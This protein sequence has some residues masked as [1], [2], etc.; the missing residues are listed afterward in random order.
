MKVRTK[1]IDLTSDE[2]LTFEERDSVA[3]WMGRD[4]PFL[5]KE[6]GYKQTH[7]YNIRNGENIGYAAKVKIRTFL[8]K[9]KK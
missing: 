3:Y 5:M 7:L 6:T 4:L 2:P 1:N 8:N 9:N